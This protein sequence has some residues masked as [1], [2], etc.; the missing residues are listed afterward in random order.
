MG[1]G[2]KVALIG[3]GAMFTYTALAAEMLAEQGINATLINPR[4]LSTLDT[5]VLDSLKDYSVVITAEDG[6]IDGGYG[7]KVASYLGEAPVKVINL[8]LPK[9]FLNRYNYSDLQQECG[10]TPDQIAATAKSSL[11][12]N[13]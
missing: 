8:G 4:N 12:L 3:A 13:P 11:T 6:I 10:L 7:Q 2:E 5:K 1:R 9:K